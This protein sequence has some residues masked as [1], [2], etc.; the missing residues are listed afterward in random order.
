[1]EKKFLKNTPQKTQA[2]KPKPKT[3]PKFILIF[4]EN[5]ALE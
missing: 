4:A 3:Q 1:M 2:K 5:Q